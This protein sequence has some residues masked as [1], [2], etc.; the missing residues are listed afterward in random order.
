MSAFDQSKSP[1][2][3]KAWADSESD[4]DHDDDHRGKRGAGR[5]EGNVDVN[6]AEPLA[7]QA[8]ADVEVTKVEDEED[9]EEEEEEEE[10]AVLGV[11]AQSTATK[12]VSKQPERPLSRKEREEMRRKELEDLDS[13]LSQLGSDTSANANSVPSESV[14]DGVNGEDQ[15]EILTGGGEA[16]R[17]RRNKKK[18]ASAAPASA[19]TPTES[20]PVASEGPRD[21]AAILK[22]RARKSSGKKAGADAGEAQRIAMQE[23]KKSAEAAKKKRDKSKFSEGSY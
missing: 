1:V 21:V 12:K 17:K 23:A 18:A 16:S 8:P 20:E 5:K 22:A 2:G 6:D 3:K 7:S 10:H 19:P 13:L 11:V 9:S 14:N 15:G 4:S